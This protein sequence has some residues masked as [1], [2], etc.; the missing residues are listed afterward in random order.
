MLAY[1]FFNINLA[2]MTVVSVQSCPGHEEV[3]GFPHKEI[4]LFAP[5]VIHRCTAQLECIGLLRSE[6]F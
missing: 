6:L 4:F 1:L 3:L 5:T 2:S